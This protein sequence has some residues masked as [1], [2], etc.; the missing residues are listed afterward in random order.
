MCL[1]SV[2]FNC[3][4]VAAKEASASGTNK[5]PKPSIT[6]MAVAVKA[7]GDFMNFMNGGSE[8]AVKDL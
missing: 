4:S 8:E 3:S 6:G 1:K 2:N 5:R 7:A